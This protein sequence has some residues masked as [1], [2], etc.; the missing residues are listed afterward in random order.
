MGSVHNRSP[1]P[2]A[3]GQFS[4]ESDAWPSVALA[5]VVS[6]ARRRAVRDA[7]RQVDTAHLLHT[8]LEADPEARAAIG[9]GPQVAR[10]LSYLV[11]RSI[12]YGLRWR[13]SVEGSPGVRAVRGGPGMPG[14]SPAAA[15]AMECA[16]RRARARGA[17]GAE[18][19]DLLAALT[20]DAESRAAEVLR[21]AGVDRQRL[22]ARLADASPGGPASGDR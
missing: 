22:A 18:G 12:G 14:W 20:A 5:S 8:L 19:L 6:G 11:Q 4:P 21:R 2:A 16:G 1:L 9:G 3:H 17:A 15:A 13:S 10:L 7:D